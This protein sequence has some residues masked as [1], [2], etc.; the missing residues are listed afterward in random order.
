MIEFSEFYFI[1]VSLDKNSENTKR[2]HAHPQKRGVCLLLP[3]RVPI[4]LNLSYSVLG[5]S[6]KIKQKTYENFD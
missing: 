6:S 4:N 1:V 5:R 3:S 2:L